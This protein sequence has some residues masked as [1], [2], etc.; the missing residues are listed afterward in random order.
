MKKDKY[1]T[2][3]E[4]EILG[5]DLLGKTGPEPSKPGEDFFLITETFSKKIGVFILVSKLKLWNG[6]PRP[7][8]DDIDRS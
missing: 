2:G 1:D 3:D 5:K 7:G 8:D 4:D 6:G